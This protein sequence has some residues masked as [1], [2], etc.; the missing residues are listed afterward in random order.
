MFIY[1]RSCC[2]FKCCGI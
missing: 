1:C 2:G